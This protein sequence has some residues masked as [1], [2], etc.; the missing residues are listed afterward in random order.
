M[1]NN[2]FGLNSYGASMAG[3][4]KSDK[5]KD[6]K[7]TKEKSTSK[8]SRS[9]KQHKAEE[10]IASSM[11]KLEVFG[12][13]KDT[14]TNKAEKPV[15]SS[16]ESAN[17]ER[18][19]DA[20]TKHIE[21]QIA[22]EHLA[23]ISESDEET[24]DAL[25][26][27]SEFLQKVS[28]GTDVETAFAEV[29]AQQ[30]LSQEEIAEALADIN[31]AEGESEANNEDVN[32]PDDVAE[33]VQE[34]AEDE[35]TIIPAAGVSLRSPTLGPSGGRRA[36][37]AA[38][39]SGGGSPASNAAVVPAV[40]VV[41]AAANTLPTAANTHFR[42]H[43]PGAELLLGGT[44]GYLMGR[45][46]GRIKLEKQRTPVQRNLEKQIVSL[47]QQI[48]Q[49]EQK[50]VAM[51]AARQ[52][53]GE[54]TQSSVRGQEAPVRIVDQAPSVR[55][56]TRLGMEKPRAERL[57]RMVVTAEAPSNKT[58][59]KIVE[60]IKQPANI[61]EA[62]RAE[63]V[64]T[65]DRTEMLLISEKITVEGASLRRIYETGLIG[66]GQLRHLVAEYLDGKD[67]RED[68]RRDMVEHEIDFERDPQMRD[69]VR[70][71]LSGKKGEGGM[72]ALLESVGIVNEKVDPTLQ[73]RIESDNKRYAQQQQ[74]KQRQRVL[75]D[76]AMATAIIVLAVAVIILVT[77]G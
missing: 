63:E 73:R 68:L 55:P 2:E 28:A 50:L 30:G 8:K 75:A 64:Q 47:E 74:S 16:E 39:P 27:A 5:D 60:R 34:V 31:Q 1:K 22:R 57:G 36:T 32:V 38:N 25:A 6:A 26:S 51:A 37:P 65:M 58:S 76:T 18:I 53:R 11:D 67:I 40:A 9:E 3:A 56:E 45:R 61:R 20:E 19:T 43:P 17:P 44:V 4:E 77:R 46:H 23:A 71:H 12:R 15:D 21:Q 41:V 24:T 59:T 33:S 42:T 29:A 62:F 10:R 48:T 7:S 13:R 72:S 49:K 54:R 35:A 52:P 66:E 70:S 69:R 14:D